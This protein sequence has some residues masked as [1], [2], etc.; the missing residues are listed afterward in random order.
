MITVRNRELVLSEF[1][2]VPENTLVMTGKLYREKFSSMI[3]EAAFAQIISRL[4]R[5]GEIERVSKGIY[6]RPRKTRFGTV[7]PSE[8]EI[9]DAFT[10]GNNGIVVGYGLY[11]AIGVT[12]QVSKRQLVYSSIGEDRQ[13]QIG[14]ITIRRYE[15]DY[16]SE[17]KSVIQLME[18]LHHYKEI[19]DLNTAAMMNSIEKLSQEYSEEAFK[20]VQKTI[21]YPKWTIAFLREVLDYHHRPNCLS[22]YLSALSNYMIP[23]MEEL[24]EAARKRNGN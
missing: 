18:L 12:T 20:N 11:N 15:L 16:T 8:C 10:E 9:V 22:R 23:S 2:K 6:C 21:G 1:Q 17:V 19:Q 13:K 14:N 5:S 4:R 24:F 7:L 3:S